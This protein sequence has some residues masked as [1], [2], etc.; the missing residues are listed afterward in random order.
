[1]TFKKS[2]SFKRYIFESTDEFL[3]EKV[4]KVYNDLQTIQNTIKSIGVDPLVDDV[5][6]LVSQIQAIVKGHWLQGQL[7]YLRV[8]QK[9]GVSLSKALDK[10]DDLESKINAAVDEIN[11]QII[12]KIGGPINQLGVEPKQ[13]ASKA[14]ETVQQPP[15]EPN[16]NAQA[17]TSG[18]DLSKA[19]PLGQPPEGALRV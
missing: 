14:P 12:T 17:P 16:I 4:G 11:N 3:K 2:F 8:L 15:T 18:F 5:K 13:S 9:V 6:R 1:M 10:D 7:P 19:P